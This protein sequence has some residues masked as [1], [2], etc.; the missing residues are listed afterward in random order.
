MVAG[1][2]RAA[3]PS[4]RRPVALLPPKDIA[5]FLSKEQGKEA[6]AVNMCMIKR[7]KDKQVHTYRS[8]RVAD[9]AGPAPKHEPILPRNKKMASMKRR[10]SVTCA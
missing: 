6:E 7:N 3:R 4:Q 10:R 1:G 5:L 9:A 2:A 8:S